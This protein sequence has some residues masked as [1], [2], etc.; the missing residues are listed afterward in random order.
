MRAIRPR[1]CPQS[2]IFAPIAIQTKLTTA[3]ASGGIRTQ[4]VRNAASFSSSQQTSLVGPLPNLPSVHVQKLEV[5]DVG[6]RVVPTRTRGY[7][8]FLRYSPCALS[9]VGNTLDGAIRRTFRMVFRRIPGPT[10]CTAIMLVFRS[11]SS[12]FQ[13]AKIPERIRRRTDGIA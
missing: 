1:A 6:S 13:G 10:D 7:L 9:A 3:A 12:S 2:H 4:Q 11:Q 5:L 8:N